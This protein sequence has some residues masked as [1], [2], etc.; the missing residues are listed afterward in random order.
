[1][2]T[3]TLTLAIG[4][5]ASFTVFA[6]DPPVEKKLALQKP[7]TALEVNGNLQVFLRESTDDTVVITGSADDIARIAVEEKSGTFTVRTTRHIRKGAVQVYIPVSRLE[8]IT[9]RGN[10][11]ITSLNELITPRLLLN[12]AGSG[13]R[14]A[15]KYYGQST[16]VGEEGIDYDISRQREYYVKN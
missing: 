7:F 4:L 13:S 2:K 15:V 14:I 9:A 6:G 12:P 11:K 10:S 8:S 5:L 16:I 1:M 3:K